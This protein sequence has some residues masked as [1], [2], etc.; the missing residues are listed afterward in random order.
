MARMARKSPDFYLPS[1]KPAGFAGFGEL[2]GQP[3][4]PLESG[5]QSRIHP[6]KPYSPVA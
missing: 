3:E 4:A 6:A 2:T 1:L 5:F